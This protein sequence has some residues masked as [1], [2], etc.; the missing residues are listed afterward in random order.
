MEIRLQAR[1]V[2]RAIPLRRRAAD[3]LLEEI[4]PSEYGFWA[5]VNP[6]F[7]HPRWTQAD[8]RDLTTKTR[9]PTRI[10]NGYG[11]FVAHLYADMPQDRRLFM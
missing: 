7:S 6:A 9:I 8:E 4:T 1:Q 3:D 2:D 5:N 11:E 10:W